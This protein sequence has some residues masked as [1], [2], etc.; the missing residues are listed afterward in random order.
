MRDV[1]DRHPPHAQSQDRAHAIDDL[2][3]S[4]FS[5]R[6]HIES[7][8]WLASSPPRRPG[9]E[10]KS[11]LTDEGGDKVRWN[12]KTNQSTSER[13][14]Y[15]GLS[16]GRGSMKWGAGGGNRE[17]DSKIRFVDGSKERDQAAFTSATV[18]LYRG[19][20]ETTNSREKR[21]IYTLMVAT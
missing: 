17:N 8:S 7:E 18:V 9:E 14:N 11:R 16:Q 4:A 19:P 21:S 12:S 15:E 1:D 10:A 20:I 5:L 6:T 3:H 13:E 2:Y